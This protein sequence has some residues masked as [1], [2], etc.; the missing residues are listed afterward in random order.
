MIKTK[1]GIFFFL[2][3]T[4]ILAISI[5]IAVVIFIG[6]TFAICCYKKHAKYVIPTEP[7]FCL[8]FNIQYNIHS[9]L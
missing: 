5:P 7:L 2:D 1:T 3:F 8:N 9:K 6:V 4:L